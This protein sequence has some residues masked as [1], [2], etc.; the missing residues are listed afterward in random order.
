MIYGF[1]DASGRGWG[2]SILLPDGSVYYK[3]GSWVEHLSKRSSNFRELANLVYSLREAGEKGLLEGCEVFMFT[4]NTT[5]EQAFF[6]GTSKSRLLFDLILELRDIE[7]K[8]G[9][10]IHL[11]HVAGT[12]M[13]YQGTD[14]L[15]RGDQIA[16]VMTG[17]NFLSH[18][19][20]HLGCIKREPKVQE[21]IASWARGSQQQP[22][23]F[24]TPEDWFLPHVSGGG[25]VWTP[26]P[27][28]A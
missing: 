9:A 12:R 20:L 1:G 21:W 3:S 22:P 17:E 18:I 13:I 11:V 5:A 14:G 24:L 26:P 2:A 6:R 16:G 7:M 8:V 23:K 4:D 25:Y 28:A 15:S 10:R 19:P 27:A